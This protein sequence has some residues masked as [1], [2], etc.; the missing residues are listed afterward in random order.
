MKFLADKGYYKFK[1]EKKLTKSAWKDVLPEEYWIYREKWENNPANF[2]LEDFPLHIGVEITTHCNLK[3]TFCVRTQNIQQGKFRKIKHM[4][5]DLFKQIIDEIKGHRLYGFCLNGIGEPLMHPDLVEMIRYS[6]EVGKMVDV[7]FH[8]N[9]LLLTPEF[10]E[11]IIKAGLDQVI[12]SIDG[13]GVDYETQRVGASYARLE[14]NVRRF[15]EIRSKLGKR[16]PFIRITMII[17][18]ETTSDN[19]NEFK[20]KWG[21]IAD[22]L[23]F[24]ELEVYDDE[25][26]GGKVVQNPNFVCPQIWQ[27]LAIDVNGNILSC[28]EANNYK[29]EMVFGKVG[30]DKIHDVWH[31]RGL[32]H[33]RELHRTHRYHENQF[34]CN[35]GLTKSV[36]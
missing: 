17:T 27:R 7:M 19:I 26:K 3:C 25:V 23:T 28:C 18:P 36:K 22:V 14:E 30:K 10:S 35:C 20:E 15:W 2:I 9:G 16:L 34:C 8:T 29:E 5:L 13:S 21:D 4:E 32:N 33:L 11:N 6:K 31:S 12:F 24:Q 1:F